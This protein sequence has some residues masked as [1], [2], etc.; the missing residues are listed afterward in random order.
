MSSS[1]FSFFFNSVVAF[2]RSLPKV[3]TPNEL[4]KNQ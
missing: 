3:E 2:D 4:E 1:Y